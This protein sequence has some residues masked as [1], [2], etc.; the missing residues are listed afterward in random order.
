MKVMVIGGR[1][2]IGTSVVKELQARHEIICVGHLDGDYQVDITQKDSIRS[3]YKKIG[4]IDAVV[5]ATGRVIFASLPKL[6]S[7][8]L[9]IGLNSKLMGQ[10]NCILIG[11]DYM[12]D[13]GSFTLTSG[14][15]NRDPIATGV[16]AAMVNGGIEGFVIGAAIEMPRGIRINV[17]S[18][19]VVTEA[20]D[21][22]GPYFRGYESVPLERV[23]RAYSKSVEGLQT[24]KIYHAR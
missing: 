23:A 12:N 9:L 11:L 10:I 14:I 4:K 16:S 8:D 7:E 24:G 21:S 19:T 15:L 22:Y 18:P 3:L 2:L 1:G 20:L 5:M 6:T 13:N 17:V